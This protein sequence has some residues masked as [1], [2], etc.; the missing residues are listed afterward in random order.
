M[1]IVEKGRTERF[2]NLK[3]GSCFKYAGVYFIKV[4][5]V[6]NTDH[7]NVL[8]AVNL[9]NGDVVYLNHDSE[10]HYPIDHELVIK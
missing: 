6:L 7:I 8:N 4:M 3:N 9:A 5:D 2:Y 1:K 10:V